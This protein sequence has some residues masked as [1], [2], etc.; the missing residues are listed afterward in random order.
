M[1][2]GLDET[3]F[4][5][6]KT[7]GDARIVRGSA[8]SVREQGVLIIGPAGAGKSTFALR[9]CGLGGLLVS[10]DLVRLAPS[11]ESAAPNHLIMRAPVVSP[12]LIEARGFG[13]IAPPCA[14]E[15]P[16]VAVLDLAF[17]E[18]DRVPEAMTLA[19]GAAEP[20]YF[21]SPPGPAAPEAIYFW[22]AAQARG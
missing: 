12:P 16:L 5:V 21:R 6:L 17:G 8:V 4:K 18:E 1:A 14:P 15:A 9:L 13:I 7:E 22:L 19:L 2:L 11:E 10:D 3:S 20:R